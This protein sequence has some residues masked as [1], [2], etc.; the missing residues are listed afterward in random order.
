MGTT[1]SFFGSGDTQVVTP[2]TG[3]QKNYSFLANSVF[4]NPT[5]TDGN[6]ATN[7]LMTPMSDTHFLVAT[8]NTDSVANNSF[9]QLFELNSDGTIVQIGSN[10]NIGNIEPLSLSANGVYGILVAIGRQSQGGYIYKITWDGNT[11]LSLTQ[12]YSDGDGTA[13]TK[14]ACLTT[15]LTDGRLMGLYSRF[16]NTRYCGYAMID[17]DGNTGAVAQKTTN[18]D[19]SS[20]DSSFGACGTGD[21]IYVVGRSHNVSTRLNG[22]KIWP[23]IN[24][25]TIPDQGEAYTQSAAV[26]NFQYFSSVPTA[27]G[28]V[29][30]NYLSGTNNTGQT[31]RRYL[32]QTGYQ[33]V[34]FLQ[35]SDTAPSSAGS[36]IQSGM[37]YLP[38][39]NEQYGATLGPLKRTYNG[40]YQDSAH[41]LVSIDA[42]NNLFP[43]IKDP[44]YS[45]RRV[46]GSGSSL[47]TLT[48]RT[49]SCLMGNT[50]V[51]LL[52]DYSNFKYNFNVWNIG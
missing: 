6:A 32:M 1:S 21:G 39:R 40:S 48:G 47:S 23:K 9:L 19:Q 28:S 30:T 20:L 25:T 26:S 16:A 2:A 8:K 37:P 44:V 7:R 27:Q 4:N 31:Y 22:M 12:L 24:S 35:F 50:I 17:T 13:A 29:I 34:N 15:V 11:T 36:G 49:N 14:K 45:L 18:F 43:A 41:S 42:S 46:V 5:G 52:N 3:F 10:L 51:S 33:P 38:E